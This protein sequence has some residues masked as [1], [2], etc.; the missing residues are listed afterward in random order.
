M[1]IAMRAYS[2]QVSTD[3]VQFLVFCDDSEFHSFHKCALDLF[4]LNCVLLFLQRVLHLD[5]SRAL[6]IFHLKAT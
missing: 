1:R 4:F 2:F 3:I 6:Q 5:R